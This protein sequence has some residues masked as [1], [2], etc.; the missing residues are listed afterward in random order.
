MKLLKLIICLFYL[1]FCFS[2]NTKGYSKE[3]PIKIERPDMS[4]ISHDSYI[5]DNNAKIEFVNSG[6]YSLVEYEN[7]F[8]LAKESNFP[9][10]INSP[11]KIIENEAN[12]ELYTA[13]YQ[14]SWIE[15]DTVNKIALSL[16]LIWIPKTENLN[17]PT[18]FIPKNENGFFL[19]TLAT[20]NYKIIG[21]KS[22]IPTQL[23]INNLN[24]KHLK[25]NPFII[26]NSGGSMYTNYGSSMEFAYNSMVL[27]G[28]YTNEEF[29]RI[30]ELATKKNWPKAFQNENYDAAYD[31]TYENTKKYKCYVIANFYDADSK[32]ALLW[33]PKGENK[34]MPLDM[35]PISEEGFFIAVKLEDKANSEFKFALY[36]NTPRGRLNYTIA[37]K[38]PL[39]TNKIEA[40]TESYENSKTITATKSSTNS[41]VSKT[42]TTAGGVQY[43]Y[44]DMSEFTQQGCMLIMQG[45]TMYVF[46]LKGGSVGNESTLASKCFQNA[47]LSGD[48]KY[49]Y[50]SGNNCE[51][52]KR[53]F[54]QGFNI[55]CKGTIQTGN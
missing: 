50:K 1:N 15:V 54:Q 23:E 40:Y 55:Y 26:E 6:K 41:Y 24:T 10:G 39:N 32:I 20:T 38:R 17:M 29:L 3:I 28:R 44:A 19:V 35:Q 46:E 18:E 31:L 14:G 36:G 33:I 4:V 34:I 7:A 8:N 25:T 13:F 51:T 48:Y 12:I 45:T 47:N 53:Q 30:K 9:E 21:L 16:N 43:S 37:G 27:N 52:I 2:Q 22:K 42:Q 5:P 49:Q 11:K